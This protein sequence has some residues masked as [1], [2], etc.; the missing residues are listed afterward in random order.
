MDDLDAARDPTPEEPD[1]ATVVDI[2]ADIRARDGHWAI[3]N[4]ALDLDGVRWTPHL[5]DADG[6][7]VLH[8]H[9]SATVPKHMTRRLRAAAAAGYG[10]CVALKLESLFDAGLLRMLA[11]VDARVYVLDAPRHNDEPTHCL[12]A[13]ADNQI[14]VSNDLR[15]EVASEQWGRRGLGSNFEKGRRL[16]ALL[17]F[18]LGQVH[19][20]RVFERNFNGETD[21]IDIAVQVDTVGNRCWCEP[22]VP[23]IVV[24][25]KNWARTVGSSVVSLLIR[26]LQTRRGRA[27]LGLLF[28]AS[29]FSSEARD[30]ELKE[31]QTSL[32]VAMLGPREIEAWI[33]AEEPDEFLERFVGRAMLR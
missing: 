18:L 4:E 32:C 7:R 26:K 6:R 19:G 21:E 2:A 30:E 13:L 15:R 23:F 31:A 12:A 29:G 8:V 10:I 14:R 25:A 5:L 3:P 11:E 24:E 27:R 1:A 33:N 9:V 22:G 17:A 28:A 20:L 16:E